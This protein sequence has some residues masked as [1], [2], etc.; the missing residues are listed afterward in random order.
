MLNLREF[1]RT[2]PQSTQ[3]AESLFFFLSDLGALCGGFV[4]ILQV[5]LPIIDQRND[6]TGKEC[7]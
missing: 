3:S 7:Y 2:E 5:H 1:L 4:L 6:Q